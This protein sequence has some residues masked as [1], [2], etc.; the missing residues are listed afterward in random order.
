MFAGLS[1]P[2]LSTNHFGQ[3]SFLR[4]QKSPVKSG[5]SSSQTSL[6]KIDLSNRPKIVIE[7]EEE[8]CD[9]NS[10]ARRPEVAEGF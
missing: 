2:I 3:V 8:N 10:Q 6:S 5:I 9:T 1:T 4:Q 7:S